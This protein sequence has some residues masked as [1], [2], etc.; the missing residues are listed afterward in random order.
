MSKFADFWG[1]PSDSSFFD[2][3]HFVFQAVF[4]GEIFFSQQIFWIFGA[5]ASEMHT[6]TKYNSPDLWTFCKSY[7][8]AQKRCEASSI[9]YACI[10]CHRYAACMNE[11]LMET[12]AKLHEDMNAWFYGN[13][14]EGYS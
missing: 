13:G 7:G 9:S 10:L 12:M 11:S 8:G 1:R 4:G 6:I 3:H 5:P 2:H 14:G